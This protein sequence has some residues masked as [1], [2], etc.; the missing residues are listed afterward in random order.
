M[1]SEGPQ[2]KAGKYSVRTLSGR[3]QGDVQTPVLRAAEDETRYHAALAR[4][5][6]REPIRAEV[7]RFGTRRADNTGTRL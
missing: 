3:P 1:R 5:S 4:A 2:N 7:H 6:Y